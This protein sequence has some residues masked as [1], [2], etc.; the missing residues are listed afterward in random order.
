MLSQLLA[1]IK[2]FTE[3]EAQSDDITVVILGRD[4]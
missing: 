2:N 1:T 4:Q 3:G